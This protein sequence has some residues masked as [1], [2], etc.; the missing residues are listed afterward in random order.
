VYLTKIEKQDF[1]KIRKQEE[2]ER[3]EMMKKLYRKKMMSHGIEM[4]G[5]TDN[6]QYL[7]EFD[8]Q[9]NLVYEKHFLRI[10]YYTT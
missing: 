3:F 4:K 9:E 6:I 8:S 5:E 10:P 1:E 7:Y 2:E